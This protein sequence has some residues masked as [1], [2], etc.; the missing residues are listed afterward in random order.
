MHRSVRSL[1]GVALLLVGVAACGSSS[2]SAAPG[3]TT[4][5]GS[6]SSV[7]AV[8]TT[9]AEV[10]SGPTITISPALKF[11]TAP[12]KAGTKVTVRNESDAQHTVTADTAAGGF[13]VTIDPH[14]TVTF[15]APS[16]PGAYGFHCNIHTFM[17]ATLTVT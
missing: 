3:T 6:T 9:T 2:K 17:K 5:S 13:D 14:Q 15:T 12:V 1:V 8:S 10:S 16:K 11:S 4:G 7:A